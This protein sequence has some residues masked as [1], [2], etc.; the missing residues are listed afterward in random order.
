MGLRAIKL[1][2]GVAIVGVGVVAASNGTL[3]SQENDA[4]INGKLIN[5]RASSE[6]PVSI[7]ALPFGAPVSQGEVVAAVA[8]SPY[9]SARENERATAGEIAGLEAQIASLE[10]LASEKVRQAELYRTGRISHLEAKIGETKD[11]VL[12]AREKEK[13]AAAFLARQ[14]DLYRRKYVA[15]TVLVSAQSAATSSR[16]ERQILEKRIVTQTVELNAA[17]QGTNIGDGY[18][19]T[20]YSMQRA[21]ELTM[22]LGDL[23]ADLLRKRI[24]N[25]QASLD[26]VMTRSTFASAAEPPRP[27]TSPVDGKVWRVLINHGDVVRSGENVLQVIDCASLF[28]TVDVT[29]RTL[30]KVTVGQHAVFSDDSNGSIGGK[31]IFAGK[32]DDGFDMVVNGALSPRRAENARARIVVALK[33]SAADQ[34]LCPVGLKG[35]LS[36]SDQP[37]AVSSLNSQ[38]RMS[39]DLTTRANAS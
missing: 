18:N 32:A 31:V 28:V 19:D 1:L 11:S 20:S 29:N 24:G 4:V 12:I 7:G 3:F 21:D 35:R 30:D 23:R 39:L 2:T 34:A 15:D 5:L 25:Q 10:A 27:V 6:G 33:P 14:E 36:F 13:Q 37:Q 38:R 17:R 9:R 26:G 16:L 22:R 8:P